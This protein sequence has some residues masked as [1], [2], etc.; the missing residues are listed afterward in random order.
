MDA[1]QAGSRYLGEHCAGLR[2]PWIERV[3]PILQRADPSWLR[4]VAQQRQR[5]QLRAD[6]RLRNI[7]IRQ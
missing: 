5:S 1:D 2:F 3:D 6:W 7:G 4:C